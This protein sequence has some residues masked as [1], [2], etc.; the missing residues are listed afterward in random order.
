M[1]VNN[2]RNSGATAVIEGVGDHGCE[3]MTGGRAVILGKTGRNFAAGMSGGI[4]YVLDVENKFAMQCNKAMVDLDP[5]DLEEDKEWLR[6]TVQEFT[7]ATGSEVGRQLL[8]NWSES[9]SKFVKV[10]P[11]EYR[12]ALQELEE[13][14]ENKNKAPVS[15]LDP[16]VDL[17]IRAAYAIDN[18]PA[19]PGMVTK[20]VLPL[21]QGET[22]S[23]EEEDNLAVKA[24]AM[25]PPIRSFIPPIKVFETETKLS[26]N[27]GINGTNGV[28]ETNG[29]KRMN[30]VDSTN[31]TNGHTNGTNGMNGMNGTRDIEDSIADLAMKKKKRE[32]LLDKTRGFVKYRRESKMYRDPQQRQQDWEE[33]FD[34]KGVSFNQYSTTTI[35]RHLISTLSLQVRR[36][37]KTQAARCMDCGVPF[38]H[39]TSHGCP[40]GNIIPKFNDL[41]FKSD[42]KEALKQLTQTNNF[43][44][45]TGRVCPAPCEGACVLGINEPPVI[46]K[47]IIDFKIFF[48]FFAI[49]VDILIFITNFISTVTIIVPIAR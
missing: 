21:E 46:I 47:K 28:K 3:Y 45:F 9:V 1:K 7:S 34:F 35:A 48:F 42:W 12:R 4:A 22:N 40:L 8:E 44:E 25:A 14:A 5:V 39:S 30:G 10:F 41:V 49:I 15:L 19:V 36:G 13:E 32:T 37:L 20:V 27:N 17:D 11:H 26:S 6:S 18:T 16:K 29:I 38:C 23:E 43:P 2:F 33:I 24:K 31:G